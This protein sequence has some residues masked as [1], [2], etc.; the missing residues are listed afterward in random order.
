MRNA[1]KNVD[2]KDLP[3]WV[4]G[5]PM[6]DPMTSGY[7]GVD[8]SGGLPGLFITIGIIV[9]PVIIGIITLVTGGTGASEDN[10]EATMSSTTPSAA[11]EQ[12]DTAQNMSYRT[13]DILGNMVIDIPDSAV[14][15]ETDEGVCYV[16]PE[17]DLRV[18]VFEIPDSG[19]LY[20]ENIISYCNE[21]DIDLQCI[22]D[23]D[24]TPQFYAESKETDDSGN[25]I[26]IYE[27][28]QTFDGT[29]YRIRV[30]SETDDDSISL[31]VFSSLKPK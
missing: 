5:D 29:S 24:G 23:P 20:P 28:Y 27:D 6:G 21:R 30:E 3:P 9:M 26:F 11:V 15:A 31:H 4:T 12:L 13:V 16:T 19:E 17:G 18:A 7:S 14:E 8:T 22:V 10:A 1:K 25:E 2:N